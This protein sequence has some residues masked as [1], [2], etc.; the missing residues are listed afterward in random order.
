MNCTR[1]FLNVEW[2]HHAWRPEVSATDY[3]TLHE[4]N[5]FGRDVTTEAVRCRKHSVCEACG[6]TTEDVECL[7]DKEYGEHCAPR[8]ACIERTSKPAV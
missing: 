8:L 4:T 6:A 1:H 2:G 7:C 5:S 3:V